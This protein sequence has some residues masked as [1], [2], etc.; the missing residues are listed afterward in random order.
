M[1]SIEWRTSAIPCNQ[2][3]LH[4]KTEGRD[5][6]ASLR[7]LEPGIALRQFYA[8]TKVKQLHLE[9]FSRVPYPEVD[10]TIKKVG[11]SLFSNVC[12]AVAAL[13]QRSPNPR[14]GACFKRRHHSHLGLRRLGL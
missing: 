14:R 13:R 11:L 10:M 12:S 8:S 7:R 9:C 4:K 2:D 5:G 3:Y 1:P 6:S